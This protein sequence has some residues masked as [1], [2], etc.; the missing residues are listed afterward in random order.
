[1][2]NLSF[3]IQIND[4]CVRNRV[5]LAP[6]SGVTDFPFR[7]RAWAAGAGLVVSEMIASAELCFGKAETMVRLN[8]EGLGLNAVQLVGR[9][10]HWM[11]EAA[12]LAQEN[13]A[14]LI[15]INM[16]CPAKKVIG[17]CA[18]SALMR[19]LPLAAELIKAVLKVAKIPVTLKM[20]LG[21]DEGQRNAPELARNAQ[22]LGI[23]M[24]TVHGR[25]RAQFYKGK[26]DWD[27]IRAVREA[28]TI[29][30]VANGDINSSEDASQALTKSGA[31]AIMVGR[32]CY[33]APWRAGELSGKIPSLDIRDY[34]RQHYLELLQFYGEGVGIRHA[35]KHLN[36]Y[37]T[38]HFE[39]AFTP[40]ER[41]DILTENDPQAVLIKLDEIFIR[42]RSG[43]EVA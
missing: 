43:G 12:I 35:R 37:L 6:M 18:G 40:I 2:I 42:S 19:D 5:F 36:W 15:D 14:D 31:D 21:W 3:P 22:A 9:D 39:K 32:A 25:T 16:G 20:R 38:K 1:M 26:A 24:V 4:V 23:S 27:A 8:G 29:P 30:L 7:K 17:G 10:P 28:I 33:G 13:G 41:R 34:I 11:Q